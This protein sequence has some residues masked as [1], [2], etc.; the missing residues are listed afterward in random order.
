MPNSYF[1]HMQSYDGGFGMVP[2]SESHGKQFHWHFDVLLYLL[3]LSVTFGSY[4]LIM[5]QLSL[6]FACYFAMDFWFS[7]FVFVLVSQVEELFVLLRLSI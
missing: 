7:L 4:H 2:G 1:Y 5:W 6:I 3:C